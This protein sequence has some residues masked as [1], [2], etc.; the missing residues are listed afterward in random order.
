MLQQQKEH[1]SY[2]ECRSSV[3]EQVHAEILVHQSGGKSFRGILSDLSTTG[4]KMSSISGVDASRP[5]FIRMPG[6][7][8]LSANVR[9]EG[10]SDYGCQFNTPLAP[11]VMQHLLTRLQI[12]G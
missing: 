5:V 6:L 2:N 8:I 10:F 1:Q 7:P 4:F 12:A 3:R 9:W 11:H